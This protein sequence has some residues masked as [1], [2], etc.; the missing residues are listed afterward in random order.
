MYDYLFELIVLGI[1]MQNLL[2][3]PFCQ[4][5]LSVVCGA[6]TVAVFNIEIQFDALFNMLKI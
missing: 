3:H 6:I 1:P 2:F 4:L 5:E